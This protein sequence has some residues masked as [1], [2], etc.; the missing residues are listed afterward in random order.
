[1]ERIKW[2]DRKKLTVILMAAAGIALILLGNL[3]GKKETTEY[4]DVKF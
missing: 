3:G 2:P 4:T 1:M